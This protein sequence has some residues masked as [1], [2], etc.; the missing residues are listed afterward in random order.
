MGSD[1]K[2][3]WARR[4]LSPF[5]AEVKNNGSCTSILIHMCS[6]RG[7]C[8]L[9]V[10]LVYCC[11]QATHTALSSLKLVFHFDPFGGE[12]YLKRNVTGRKVFV[13]DDLKLA[14]GRTGKMFRSGQTCCCSIL[15]LMW[16]AIRTNVWRVK[17]GKQAKVT[18][19]SN[20]CRVKVGKQAKMTIRSKV[21][22][23]KVGKQAK[24]SLRSN[25]KG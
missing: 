11:K 12:A 20:A 14:S 19:M 7:Q 10:Y 2:P 25:F 6:W 15:S 23:V 22:S 16:M 18:L 9:Y 1:G 3:V 21:W 24:M 13:S 8:H 17:V 5:S 4:W